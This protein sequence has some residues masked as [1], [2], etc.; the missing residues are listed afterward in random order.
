MTV[1]EMRAGV[2]AWF[3]GLLHFSDAVF[4]QLVLVGDHRSQFQLQLLPGEDGAGIVMH[5]DAVVIAVLEQL[6]KRLR[7][8]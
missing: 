6:A 8:E 4:L 3:A 7:L 1:M 2:G 5:D